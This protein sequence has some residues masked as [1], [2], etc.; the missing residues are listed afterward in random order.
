MNTLKLLAALSIL[1]VATLTGC[2]K[3]KSPDAVAN[4]VAAARQN[5]ADKIGEKNKDLNNVEAKGEYDVSVAKAEGDH[6]VALEKCNALSGDDQSK[7]KDMADADY[8]ATKAN[9]KAA[10]VATKQ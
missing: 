9:A 10:E 4:E 3:A 8:N 2:N 5:E 7:C 1:S 6:K